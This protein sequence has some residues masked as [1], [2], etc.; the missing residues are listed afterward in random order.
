MLGQKQ[1][2]IGILKEI[3]FSPELEGFRIGKHSGDHTD[4]GLGKRLTDSLD[5][6]P[7][8][9]HVLLGGK[10][11]VHSKA[12]NDGVG[13][14]SQ[15]VLFQG[16]N[17]PRRPLSA[18][19]GVHV[20]DI[21]LRVE[22]LQRLFH[23]DRPWVGK[24][25]KAQLSAGVY[26]RG[27]AVAKEQQGQRLAILQLFQ[28]LGKFFALIR[29]DKSLPFVIVGIGRKDLMLSDPASLSKH[30]PGLFGESSRSAV[31]VLLGGIKHLVWKIRH[32]GALQTRD[33]IA[34]KKVINSLS[35]LGL[36]IAGAQRNT[37]TGG[38]KQGRRPF[39]SRKENRFVDHQIAAPVGS[40]IGLEIIPVGHTVFQIHP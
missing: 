24:G 36:Q 20:V 21:C 28:S 26:P 34:R 11:V 8:L 25:L 9:C 27:D 35:V 13:L 18:H 32:G 3:L 10:A 40:H 1:F 16:L 6:L 2:S 14:I 33:P 39:L 30:H 22:I 29:R 19:G 17:P 12:E 7:Q 38:V 4:L 37:V 5:Q 15:Q 23:Q 31:L